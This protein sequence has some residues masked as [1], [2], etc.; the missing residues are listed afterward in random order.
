MAEAWLRRPLLLAGLTAVYFA[1]G[2]FGLSLAVVNESASAVWP[3]TG[4]AVAALLLLGTGA[5]PA[6]AVGA[7]AVNLTTSG[8]VA[9][10]VAIAAGNALEGIV[11]AELTV[12]F[13]R[14]R[15]AYDHPGD[16]VRFTAGAMV[17]CAIAAVVGTASLLTAGLAPAS[18]AASIWLTWWL[19][20]W[21]GAILIAP[22][23]L[24][25]AGRP[26]LSWTRARAAEATALAVSLLAVSV[27]VFEGPI[28]GRP[29]PLQFLVV[30]VLL[31]PAFRFGR[32]VTAT[33][34]ALAGGVAIDGTLRGLG[35]FAQYPVNESL[36]LL[37]AFVGVTTMV[38]LMVAAEVRRRRAVE[39]EIRWLN[40]VLERRVSDRT[41]EL[42]RV[43]DRLSEA[44][45]VAHIGSWE[46]SVP[47]DTLWW[48]DELY[49]IYGI[50]RGA[51]PT[52]EVF[53]RYVHPDDRDRIDAAVRRAMLDG[54]PFAFDHR[55]L[56]P[57]GVVRVLHAEGRVVLENGRPVRMMGIGH[58]ITE[59]RQAEEARERESG[60]R[61]EAEEASRAKDRFLATL[62]HEL[63][64]PLNAA[65]G[66]ARLLMELPVGDER[67][68]RGVQAI[69]R[70]LTIQVRLVSD[71]LDV[72]RAA[73]GRLALERGPID[74]AA[75]VQEAIDMVRAA[76]DARRVTVETS[77]LDR[78]VP[79][80][81]DAQRL[82]QV[83]WN[84]L[85][86]ALRFSGPEAVVSV[87][88][89]RA[90]GAVQIVVADDGPGIDAALLPHV[91]DEFRQGD[92]SATRA[93]RGLGLGLAIARRIVEQHGGTIDA[94]NRPDGG[95]AFTIS[96]PAEGPMEV[97]GA[98]WHRPPARGTMTGER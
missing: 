46:W 78:P 79:L 13:A 56:R 40:D 74:A 66:W 47:D 41:Q 29:Y 6:I 83:V 44:Q 7:F 36:L 50:D 97:E 54:Q 42:I 14:G 84:L 33:S 4:I 93:H 45:Q 73:A 86:N 71:I 59:S 35:P 67:L 19:G 9:S 85:D 38:L 34:A 10:S 62:S 63:R 68:H 76:A 30:A 52:Y 8:V 24:L 51:M 25:W 12:R 16:I 95:A 90:D 15:A 69:Y 92:E 31:W 28:G 39:A 70:N 32:R 2:R 26:R 77:G 18:D 80:V 5:W 27:A 20:D 60:A 81:G 75:V 22:L 43:Y 17:A 21:V 88:L 94:A 82:Q 53:L 91:F 49:R 3:P 58:D 23:I 96:I 57:D 55:I 61:R 98:S 11:A 89:R 48:S 64:T 72:S 37:Q 87:A 65:L 1:A